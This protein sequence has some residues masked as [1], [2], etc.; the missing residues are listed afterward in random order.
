MQNEVE[1]RFRLSP[2]Q[3]RLWL[4]RPGGA[5]GAAAGCAVLLEGPLRRARLEDALARVVARH[6]ILRT[7]FQSV[8]GMKTPVQVVGDAAP[9]AWAGADLS[10]AGRQ[11]QSA[12]T[13]LFEEELARPF[14]LAAGPL[15]RATLAALAPQRHALVLALPAVC[16]DAR[17]LGNLVTE[18]A[19]AYAGEDDE[20]EPLQYVQFSEWQHELLED[21]EE[22]AGREHW[23]RHDPAEWAAARLP[24]ERR[25]AGSERPETRSAPVPLAAGLVASLRRVAAGYDADLAAVLAACWQTLLWHLLRQPRVVVGRVFDGRAHEELL[26]AFGP[27]ARRLPVACEFDETTPFADVLRQAAEAAREGEQWQEYFTG[28]AAASPG[29]EEYFAFG[30]EYE[31]AA[32]EQKADG[33]SFSLLRQ[34]ACPEPAKLSL[35]CTLVGGTL[36]GELIYDAALYTDEEVERLAAQLAR[37]AGGVA[38]D[39][40]QAVASLRVVGE[41]DLRRLLVEFNDTAAPYPS[42][43]CLHELFE[44]QARL[45]P[46]APALVSGGGRLTYGE[47]NRR[48]NRL[49][50]RLR[51]L[52]VGAEDRVALLLERSADSVVAMLAALKAGAAYVPLESAYPEGRLRAMLADA[53]AKVVLTHERLAETAGGGGDARV[54]C[55]DAES[56]LADAESE[57]D[58]A[59]LAGADNVAYV[60]YTS[61]STGEP[62]GVAVGH[63]QILNYLHSIRE[64]LGLAECTSFATVSTF[65]ADLGNTVIFPALAFGGCL[66]VVSQETASDGRAF[67]RYLEEHE[68]DCLKIVPS[69]LEALLS[70]ADGM[71]VVPRRRLIVGGEASRVELIEALRRAAPDCAFFNHYGPTETTVGVLTCRVGPPDEGQTSGT[72]PLGRPVHNTRV[73]VLDSGRRPVPVWAPGELYVG[74]DNVT[75]GYLNRPALTAERFVPDPFSGEPGAR[76][77][78]TGDLARYLPDGRVEFLGRVDHQV[79]IRGYR[80]EPGEVEAALAAHEGVR[81]CVVVAREDGAAGEKRL[82]A[83]VVAARRPSPAVAELR[84]F[85]AGRLPEHM[86]PA[87]FVALDSLPLTP[88]GK[89]D[90][91]ALPSPEE[92]R[93]EPERPFVAPRGPVE[94]VVADI[95]KGLLGVERVGVLDNFFELGGHSL[96]AMRVV[97]RLRETFRVEVPLR[98]LFEAT[99]VEK[100]ARV[101]VA[102]EPRPGQAENVARFALK[103]K[104]MSAEDLKEALRARKSAKQV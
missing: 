15:V 19:R 35:A 50:H 62:K 84:G 34:R 100:L 28:Q 4:S 25:P 95:W 55:L 39:A 47:L 68:I 38:A 49:A 69:H 12:L 16:A 9:P 24:F 70:T 104:G 71:R 5:G 18:L 75:R 41:E 29:R 21:E 57:D 64:R 11:E 83:Y 54:L 45:R 63:R 52:G 33:L 46:D 37:L 3:R 6:E 44:E 17:T 73:Y 87:A 10:G 101:L 22:Q 85:L 93:S 92:A 79:K 2:Q 8:P 1:Q 89:T 66:H 48:A 81:E 31:E 56:Q 20:D 76:L 40:G 90:L 91:R 102:H 30:F 94:E 88:N 97:S 65:A 78:R 36:S 82:V 23:R 98:A 53:G 32:G 51:A 7:T 80:I 103:I 42:D 14:D 43:R 74:G 59:P 58:P 26:G 60:V 67:A 77:Y 13:S 96:L 99:T 61:G 72:L 86:I 27:F